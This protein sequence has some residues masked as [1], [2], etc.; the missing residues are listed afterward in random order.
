MNRVPASYFLSYMFKAN[1]LNKF[2]EAYNNEEIESKFGKGAKEGLMRYTN[3]N[4][5]ESV[6]IV[7]KWNSYE[8]HILAFIHKNWRTIPYYAEL[9]E[10]LINNGVNVN[11]VEKY[12]KSIFDIVSDNEI[13]VNLIFQHKDFNKSSVALSELV[14]RHY[15]HPD[16]VLMLYKSGAKL[17]IDDLIDAMTDYSK[18]MIMIF[19]DILVN[20]FHVDLNKYKILLKLTSAKSPL[21]IIDILKKYPTC[22]LHVKDEENDNVNIIGKLISRTSLGSTALQMK[23]IFKTIDYLL[24]KD[25]T[26]IKPSDSHLYNMTYDKKTFNYLFKK[27]VKTDFIDSNKLSIF[28]YLIHYDDIDCGND[29]IEMIKLCDNKHINSQDEDGNTVLLRYMKL[30][31]VRHNH[32]NHRNVLNA[33]I[34]HGANPNIKN[35]DNHSASM[36]MHLDS[37]SGL[38][39]Y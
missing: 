16:I 23:E 13:M 27:G 37:W 15:Y 18:D 32:D 22:D 7:R 20:D 5:N 29:I 9:F 38:G 3:E 6:K 30:K 39:Y 26:L 28:D 33:L 17:N 24:K 34:S 1:L 11:F 35:N 10:Y 8:S 14:K 31:S 21:S 19:I 12:N 36:F 25:S 2:Y 4:I